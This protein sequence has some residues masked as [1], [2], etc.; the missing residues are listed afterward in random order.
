MIGHVLDAF[1][2]GAT[3]YL[4]GA[5]GEILALADA[6]A[7]DPQRMAGVHLVSCLLPGM[8]GTDY[9]ALAADAR[10]TTFM[11]PPALRAS[12]AA[13]R[14]RLLALGYSDIARYLEQAARIDVAV[15]HLA[16][17]GRDGRASFG[18][19]A[20]FSPIAWVSARMRIAIINPMMPALPRSPS[21]DLADADLVVELEGKLIELA[22]TPADATACA[23][24]RRAAELIPD[25]AG[26]QIG[27]GGAPAALWRAL[28]GHRGLHL[29]SGMAAEGMC[30]LDEA[31]ALADDAGHVAGIAAGSAAF[32]RYLAARDLVRLADT[33]E[34]HATAAIGLEPHFIAANSALEVDLLGQAN[35]E[36]HAGRPVSGIGGA[37]DFAAA[38]LR[39][40][41]GRAIVMLPATARGGTVSRI[42]ARL[43][44]PAVSLPR[45][46]ADTIVT[47]HGVAELRH[48]SLDERAAAMMAIA[49]PAWRD[50]LAEQWRTMRAALN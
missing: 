43:A 42:V 45:G 38:A 13:G 32:Y 10:I 9:A 26:I 22:T 48:A 34:T 7:T 46:L 14:V 16:P 30:W 4:P 21:V 11:L 41:G 44:G 31:G 29:R 8:N 39:S 27:I 37:A 17:P 20:D 24:G 36:W 50:T 35:L 47:E 28:T 6:L 23:I 19:A 1:R 33:R 25:G 12:F 2:P 5:T 40:A 18:I 15:A 49:D 3:I